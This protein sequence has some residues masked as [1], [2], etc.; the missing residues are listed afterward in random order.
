[1]RR[2]AHLAGRLL[3][4]IFCVAAVPILV[5]G[6]VRWLF[7]VPLSAFH[8][9]INDEVSYWHQALTFSRVGFHGGYYTLGELTNASGVTPFGPHGPGFAVTFGSFGALLGWHRHSPVVL[10]LV[11]IA[12]AAGLWV[13]LARVNTARLLVSGLLLVTFWQMSFW[14]ATGMQEGLHEA[15][16]IAMAAFFAY[17]LGEVPARAGV[18]AGWLVLIALAMI[19]PSWVVLFP[20]WALVTN[21]PRTMTAWLVNGGGSCLLAGV[22]IAIY[23]RMV[24]PFP[25]GFF[26][27]K[28]LDL[29]AGTG[30][31][32]ANVLFNV[33]RTFSFGD[34]EALELL[35]RAQYWAWLVASFVVIASGA[36]RWRTSRTS[37]PSLHLVVGA[38]A[39]AG[40]VVLLFLLYTLTNWAEHRILSAF[41]LFAALLCV[42]APGRAPL[43]IT[44]ALVVSNIL[45][46]STFVSGF[47]H[48][49]RDNFIWDRRGVSELSD[50]LADRVIYRADASRWCN[51]LLTA[52]YPP[53]LI[54]V[55]AGIG[56]SVV[57]EGDI[58]PLPP[59]SQYLLIDQRTRAEFRRPVR[60]ETLATLPYGT[61]YR[62]LESG[63]P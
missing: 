30:A 39:L 52:Q 5:I 23:S 17:A 41:L 22:V 63:C 29:S 1:M 18:A 19:R 61:L 44:L 31:V 48:A 25:T 21:R 60:L 24:A 4:V 50:A 53:F 43:A 49:R 42:A 26:F 32:W 51:T 6:L 56:L 8:P 59:H 15:G 47:E 38:G 35:H 46:T 40:A 34:Y 58:L 33:R 57:R 16:A 37:S 2:G 14:A 54:A 3:A 62:N 13:T 12:A 45:M 10:N 7:G 27:L 20:F 55:P 36:W 11:V 28:A 9:V